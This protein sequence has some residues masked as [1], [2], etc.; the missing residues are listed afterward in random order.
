[1]TQ[2]SFGTKE[3]YNL[4]NSAGCC[5]AIMRSAAVPLVISLPGRQGSSQTFCKSSSTRV[6]S[7]FFA[8][9]RPLPN[10]L[11]SSK[12]LPL[13]RVVLSRLSTHR[14][15]GRRREPS[16]SPAYSGRGLRYVRL[17]A[18]ASLLVCQA[19]HRTRHAMP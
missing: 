7:R 8:P 4:A 17:S 2:N 16:T 3:Q 18:L 9:R 14:R 1:D 13:I 10:L 12:G 15:R 6:A 11:P 5:F 19:R